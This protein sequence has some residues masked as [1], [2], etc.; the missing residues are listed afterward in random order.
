MTPQEILAAT[1]GS[2]AIEGMYASETDEKHILDVLT[3]RYSLEAVVDEIRKKHM[4]A[5]HT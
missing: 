2:F 4:V 1:K 5:D 3:G